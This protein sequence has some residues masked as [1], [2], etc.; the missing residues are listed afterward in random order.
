MC[1]LEE[2]DAGFQ[3]IQCESKT[4]ISRGSVPLLSLKETITAAAPTDESMAM[5]ALRILAHLSDERSN[6]E[7]VKFSTFKNAGTG[8]DQTPV[9]S[10][11]W[12]WDGEFDVANLEP[13]VSRVLGLMVP[14]GNLSS[15]KDSFRSLSRDPKDPEDIRYWSWQRFCEM[16]YES[17]M[18]S[19]PDKKHL[20]DAFTTVKCQEP[21]TPEQITTYTNTFTLAFQDINWTNSTA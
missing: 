5:S 1:L 19:P 12:T 20:L 16:L 10:F 17:T 3:N 13:K 2:A 4:Q 14:G 18:Y 21:G 11:I 6:A 9:E 15:W 8:K 7:K